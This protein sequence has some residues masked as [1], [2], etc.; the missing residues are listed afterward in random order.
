MSRLW[1]YRSRVMTRQ[2]KHL[3]LYVTAAA[4]FHAGTV[5]AG[6]VAWQPPEPPPVE[7]ATAAQPIEFVYL[8]APDAE[9][10]DASTRRAQVSQKAA[11]EKSDGLPTN[12]GK[13]VEFQKSVV[14]LAGSKGTEVDAG[15]AIAEGEDQSKA[16]PQPAAQPSR[17]IAPAATPAASLPA[18]APAAAPPAP[19]PAPV[20]AA[21]AAPA[22]P[23]R[24]PALSPAPFTP[25]ALVPSPPPI[26]S[27]LARPPLPPPQPLWDAP[28][29]P[30]P[31]V[32]PAPA[33]PPQPMPEVAIA[34]NPAAAPPPPG[35]GLDGT[36]NP[37]TATAAA[38]TPG[39]SARRD[40]V[41]GE[42]VTRL[43]QEVH[44]AWQQVPIDRPYR[45]TVRLTLDRAGN[46]LDLQLAEPSGFADADAAAIA[47]VQQSA[48]F[49][50]F[51]T[52]ATRDRIRVNLT[53][54]YNLVN[55]GLGVGD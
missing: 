19:A 33:R 27:P 40:P 24:L 50:P 1:R 52:T 55:Q 7:P 42:Y 53:F 25:P 37:D 34:R 54:N 32:S 49:E 29:P 22:L 26:P 38:N 51:P 6:W 13:A 2:R 14:P 23:N 4:A 3:I 39:L 10:A 46:L 44:E 20:A 45:V 35:Q 18:P 9:T 48:P 16:L 12:A 17:P 5:T 15:T 43:N 31:D 41:W 8:D 21:P 47:A 30:P 36:A 11:G 28:L